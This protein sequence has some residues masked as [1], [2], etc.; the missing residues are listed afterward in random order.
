MASNL[1]G[2]NIR[3]RALEPEDVNIMY[4]WENDTN[5][6]KVSNTIAPFSKYM[7]RQFVENQRYDI[8][9]TG[10]LRLIVETKADSRPIGAVDLFDIDPYNRRAGVGVLIYD[11]HDKRQGYASESLGLMILYAFQTLMLNQLYCNISAS[12]MP[13]MGLFQAKGFTVIGLKKEWIKTTSDW[14]DEYMLQLIN[15]NKR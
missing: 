3:L 15:P 11:G 2:E 10:Q 5:V 14:L 8:F 4:R 12:N 9:E 13:S 7:L 1:E 6:W